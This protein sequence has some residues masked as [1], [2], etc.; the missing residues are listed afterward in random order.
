MENYKNL[1]PID[2]ISPVTREFWLLQAAKRIPSIFF[3]DEIQLPSDLQVSVGFVKGNQEKVLGVCVISKTE[4][5]FPASIVLNHTIDDTEKLLQVLVHECIHAYG[6]KG[7]G[8][9]FGKFAS[10][11]GFEKPYKFH[12]PG[13]SLIDNVKGLYNDLLSEFGPY[14]GAALHASQKEKKERNSNILTLSCP[15]CEYKVKVA[16]KLVETY[17]APK[18]PVHNHEMIDDTPDDGP[19]GEIS[20]D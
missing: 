6:I 9:A 4:D 10:M 15:D 19:S 18:C 8:K 7:H 11:A 20:N 12:T 13:Q 14:P 2:G 16:R 3:N 17:G 1:E 5:T